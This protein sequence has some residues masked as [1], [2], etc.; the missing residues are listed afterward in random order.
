MLKLPPLPGGELRLAIRARAPEGS[1]NASVSVGMGEKALGTVSFKAADSVEWIRFTPGAAWAEPTLEFRC[2]GP[3]QAIGGRSMCLQVSA[4]RLFDAQGAAI[5]SFHPMTDPEMPESG[6]LWE[7]PKERIPVASFH[8]RARAVWQIASEQGR[9]VALIGWWTS[10]PAEDLNGTV[11]SAL[12]GVHGAHATGSETGWFDKFPG[13]ASPEGAL[14][15]ARELFFPVESVNEDVQKEFYEPGTCDCVGAQQDKMFRDFYWQDRY[16]S[17]LAENLLETQGQPNLMAL[18]LRGT[19]STGHMFLHIAG[20]QAFLDT[21]HGDRCDRARLESIVENYYRYIDTEIGRLLKA[22][23]PDTVVAIVTDHGQAP[24]PT[25][26]NHSDNGFLIL[27]GGPVQARV[28]QGAKVADVT[29]TLL[30]LAGLPVAQDMDGDVLVQALEPAFVE[31]NPIRFVASYEK[32]F[33]LGEKAEIVDA[34]AMTEEE[35]RMK[36]LGYVE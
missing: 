10:W 20:N 36:A 11:Y 19:D 12:L 28:L 8:R 24:G 22:T 18:Y 15:R 13:L 5:R 6:W 14:D 33:D 9:K 30:Y 29:P 32:P 26:G 21:C 7:R 4:L 25:H 27:H 2:E 35:E 3:A 16:F 34:D 17:R 23:S 31:K 1:S